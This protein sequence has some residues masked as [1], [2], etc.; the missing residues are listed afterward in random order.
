[1]LLSV[2]NF[3]GFSDILDI[4]LWYMKNKSNLNQPNQP[5]IEYLPKVFNF[6][7]KYILSIC[8]VLGEG[9]DTLLQYCCLANL[10]DGGA[11]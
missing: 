2:I 10:M 1:M 4:Y 6:C 5:V 8:Q 9:N 3:Q 11:W 7:N